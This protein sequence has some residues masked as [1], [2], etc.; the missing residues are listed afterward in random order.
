MH[1]YLTYIITILHDFVTKA[2]VLLG[3]CFKQFYL[4]SVFTPR[5]SVRG[6]RNG[7]VRV[8]V[9]LSVSTLTAEPFDV[10]S[11]Y[12][13]QGLILMTSWPGLMVK[14]IGQRSRSQGQECHFRGFLI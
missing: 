10:W 7:P 11:R 13:V 1:L 6:Y 5:V 12:L 14:V 3:G 4:A 8:C 2:V 9:C